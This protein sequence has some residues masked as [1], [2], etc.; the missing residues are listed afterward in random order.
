[1]RERFG[2]RNGATDP[3]AGQA[4]QRAQ[5]ERDAPAP[6]G[7]VGL[8]ENGGEDPAHGRG[9]Q[10]AD[11]GAEEHEAGVE[12]A[13][14]GRRHFRQKGRGRGIL[15][16]QRQALQQARGGQ[17]QGGGN[18]DGGVGGR[19][20][21][22]ERAARHHEDRQAQRSLAAIAVREDT[23]HPAADGT[24][25]KAHREDAERREQGGGFVARRKELAGKEDGERRVDGPIEP[26]HR[27]A[28]TTGQNRAAA[29][30][31]R[32]ACPLRLR[33]GC[34][35]AAHDVLKVG[36]V[37]WSNRPIKFVF[38]SMRER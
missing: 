29:R 6:L 33:Q 26:F 31:G 7:H 9:G 21:D 13:L 12:A 37:F 14:V 18:A 3:H 34:G 5:H 38:L 20:G 28:Y 36:F 1:M 32:G 11:R 16:A 4:A 24:H 35:C 30:N 8:G 2:F 15:S 10:D 23:Q 19:D 17:Q 25:E 27:I 22:D